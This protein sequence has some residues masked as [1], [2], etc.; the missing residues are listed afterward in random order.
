MEQQL[1]GSQH[2]LTTRPAPGASE[3]L[4]AKGRDTR[5]IY[6]THKTSK[7][8]RRK[9]TL[10]KQKCSEDSGTTVKI[11][12]NELY[13]F[14][15]VLGLSSLEGLLRLLDEAEALGVD[16]MSAGVVLSWATEAQK[17]GLISTRETAGIALGW[18]HEKA[19]LAAIGHR[20]SQ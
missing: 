2:I 12:Q 10:C 9:S 7:P 17:K 16:V 5:A 19:F 6:R 13:A 3:G 15:S 20:P 4:S 11:S 18:G 8:L 14:G 1:E